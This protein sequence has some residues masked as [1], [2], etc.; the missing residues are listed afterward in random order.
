MK[1]QQNKSSNKVNRCRVGSD[2]RVIVPKG[3]T[4]IELLVVCG[5]I[6]LLVGLLLP[7]LGVA[8]QS[9]QSTKCLSNLR[10]IGTAV[11]ADI[12][13]H[14]GTIPAGIDANGNTL[15][16]QLVGGGYLPGPFAAMSSSTLATDPVNYGSALICPSITSV[17]FLGFVDPTTTPDSNLQAWISTGGTDTRYW[18]ASNVGTD[19]T[20]S[21]IAVQSSYGIN[22]MDYSAAAPTSKDVT[23]MNQLATIGSPGT[24]YGKLHNIGEIA[25]PS[26]LVIIA[27]GNQIISGKIKF[28]S[29]RH[30]NRF[31]NVLMLDGHAE[32]A[33]SAALPTVDGV[34][35]T[36]GDFNNASQPGPRWLINQQ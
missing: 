13:D 10:Q 18:L 22:G 24:A 30:K 29:T 21:A 20:P 27:D 2:R 31:A 26:R 28:L 6:A 14:N 8:R 16:V 1:Q 5:I 3:F 19:T 36:A 7:A 4:L 33:D 25:N 15:F 35:G 11:Q 12:S 34:T 32:T 23:P 9:A 17:G